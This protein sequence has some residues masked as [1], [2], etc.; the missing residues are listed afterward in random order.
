QHKL[1][2]NHIALEALRLLLAD[3]AARYDKRS[4]GW[5]FLADAEAAF[6]N[7]ALR[8]VSLETQHAF[9]AIGYAE[10]HEAPR[11]FKQVHQDVLRFGGAR[12][13]REA[14][15]R[16]LLD[17]G[18][19]IPE[20]DLGPEGNA[21]RKEVGQWLDQ[22]WTPE[23][24]AA[25]RARPNAH[26]EFDPEFAR[27][28]G[29]TGWIGLNW[30]KQFGGQD[31]SPVEYVAFIEQMER[32]EAPRAGAPIQS[33]A[34]MMFGSEEQQQRY[35]P[36]ILRGE[37]IY[38]MWYSEPDS[39]SDLASLR[40][41]AVRDGDHWVVNGQK[42]WTTTYW[43]DYMWL[44]VRTDAEAKPAHA[45]I[46]VFC[47]PTNTPG[48]TIRPMKTM[49]DGEFVNTFFDNVRIPASALVGKL[50][51][52]W[53][54]LTGS[55]GT[56]RSVVGAT[57]VAKLTHAFELLCDY[58]RRVETDSGPLRLDPI[59]RDQIGSLAGQLE[60]ARQLAMHCVT[61]SGQ[62]ESPQH[63]AAM[64]KVFG[65]E[66]MERMFE[67]AQDILG[68]EAALSRSSPGAILQGRLEQKL[69]HSLMWVISLGTNE[70]QRNVIAQR[71]LGLPR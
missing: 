16:H 70:I 42:I 51:G 54:V 37:V 8:Q 60:A 59:V 46:S 2:N 43:G 62:G 10:E 5:C 20:Y 33:V 71:G 58:I 29:A 48:I 63:L 18:L 64:T 56:E 1:T 53:E 50:N 66:L 12:R 68:M 32:A 41:R 9:G 17:D 69:R 6:S 45:G 36:E 67:A 27:E 13:A 23:R 52:G 55:L 28:L 47:V 19:A 57:V 26:R 24:Q 44:A 34:W 22:H 3:T 65:G 25:M 7:S 61:V 39:G 21:F 49:Y 15:A 35:L 31:R 38:G 30:P 4:S 14:L 11:H 40:T